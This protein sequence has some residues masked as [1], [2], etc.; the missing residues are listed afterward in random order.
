VSGCKLA[1]LR[2]SPPLLVGARVEQRRRVSTAGSHSMQHQQRKGGQ[3]SLEGWWMEVR[4]FLCLHYCYYMLGAAQHG[5]TAVTVQAMRQHCG[6]LWATGNLAAGSSSGSSSSN[7]RAVG[8]MTVAAAR[9]E[10]GLRSSST[11][12]S[13]SS[14]GSN[15][16]TA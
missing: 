14:N 5:T 6:N 4:R 15:D 10:P 8:G 2:E 3:R 12:S 11:S 9:Q 13:R 7:N 1:P 16:R